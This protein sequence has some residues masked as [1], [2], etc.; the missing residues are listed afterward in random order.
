MA[1]ALAATGCATAK[2]VTPGK[3]PN[4]VFILSDDHN[5]RALG[6]HPGSQVKT[7]NLDRI[8]KEGTHF[9]HCV[10]SSPICTPSRAALITGQSGYRSGVTFFS[11]PIAPQAPRIPAIL[12][13]AGYNT[14]FTGKWHNDKR[15]IDHG[16]QRMR[17]VFLGGMNG[18][19]S[20]PVVE[21][22]D[23]KRKVIPRPPAEV[24]TDAALEMLAD[25]RKDS[26][27]YALFAW[28][29]APH[30]PR[31]PP[32][33]YDR[34]YEPEKMKLPENFMAQPPFDPLTLD[35]R[36]EKLQPRPL[37]PDVMKRET[38]AYYGLIS[39]LD[40]QVG[41][42]IDDLKSSGDWDNT[43]L[44]FAGDNGLT[45]GAH[46]L[47]GKQTMYEEGVRVP[48][49]VCGPGLARGAQCDALVDLMDI[50]PT[51]CETARADVPEAVEGRSLLPLCRGEREG[52][53]D[54]VFCYYD[55]LQRMVRTRTHKLVLH[56]KSG[57]EEMFDLLQDPLEL[58][59]IHDSPAHAD[60]RR[61]LLARLNVWRKQSG[62]L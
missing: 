60:I 42:L 61:E 43:L 9:T 16:F 11:K 39:H 27:P 44:V 12:S 13:E 10:V 49:I 59:D 26:K 15:P 5:F 55:N 1:G 54:A 35:I 8:A 40:A 14:A 6:C 28:Y 18:H 24:F 23:D 37:D 58:K 32:A 34:M 21:G 17:H 33:P 31:T 38:A 3:R 29:T 51:C 46:G 36:D 48:L 53:R 50:M 62:D 20:I 4:I 56:L 25:L 22:K 30:D 57:R 47:L 52:Q 7:P 2:P 19:D 45:L 41:R